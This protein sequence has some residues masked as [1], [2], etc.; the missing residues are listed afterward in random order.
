MA[1][2]FSQPLR[3]ELGQFSNYADN[4]LWLLFYVLEPQQ[5]INLPSRNSFTVDNS[6]K[7]VQLAIGTAYLNIMMT[8]CW[9]YAYFQMLVLR[10]SEKSNN[11]LWNCP[12]CEMR[13]ITGN[14]HLHHHVCHEIG[15]LVQCIGRHSSE[16]MCMRT[17]E[18]IFAEG[19]LYN[20][21]QFNK[22]VIRLGKLQSVG[23]FRV[24]IMFQIK[25]LERCSL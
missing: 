3:S 15:R 11:S 17:V 5:S 23:P 19:T 6:I 1:V 14:S 20:S 2:T 25:G 4:T 24:Q 8:L 7:V 21:K 13:V 12:L 16:F 10:F 9:I 18:G 22:N